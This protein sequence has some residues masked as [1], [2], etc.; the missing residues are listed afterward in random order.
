MLF[1]NKVNDN[2]DVEDDFEVSKF[3][4]IIEKLSSYYIIKILFFICL[5]I[6]IVAFYFGPVSNIY[7]DSKSELLIPVIILLSLCI[8]FLFNTIK[9]YAR[10]I[11]KTWKAN[12]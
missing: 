11:K 1:F 7:P 3:D 2:V 12:R 9:K 6:S 10:K 4:I 8:A 5:I